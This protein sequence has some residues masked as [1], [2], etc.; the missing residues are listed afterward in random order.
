MDISHD[1]E[2]SKAYNREENGQQAPVTS[3]ATRCYDGNAL[4]VDR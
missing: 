2:L 1:R 3:T 4:G